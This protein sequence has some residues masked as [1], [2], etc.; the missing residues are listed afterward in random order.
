MVLRY[1]VGKIYRGNFFKN[2]EA[3]G[4]FSRGFNGIFVFVE[5][6]GGKGEYSR[7]GFERNI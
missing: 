4:L 5:V 3:Y 1:R 2:L 7:D 6:V